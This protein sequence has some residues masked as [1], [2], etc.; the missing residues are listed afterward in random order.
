LDGLAYKSH[1]SVPLQFQSRN[2]KS[3]QQ[4]SRTCHFEYNF[5]CGS[6]AS[7]REEERN[8]IDGSKY[9]ID[10]TASLNNTFAYSF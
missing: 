3:R 1:F 6:R 8:E 9:L 4:C 7:A 2:T 10:R 5:G